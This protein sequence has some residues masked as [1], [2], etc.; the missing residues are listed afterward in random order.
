M[1]KLLLS[2]FLLSMFL[3]SQ[4]INKLILKPYVEGK[5]MKGWVIDSIRMN[6]TATIVY[7]QFGLGRG[8]TSSGDLDS[9]I[10]IPVTGKHFKQTGLK[11]LPF[12]PEKII[13]I[14]Q[15][16]HFEYIFPP[17]DPATKCINITNN[18]FDGRGA[19]WYGVWLVPRITVFTEQLSKLSTIEG[20]WYAYNDTG[21]WKAGFYEH[22]IFWN[23]QFWNF[24][25]L[26][27]TDNSATIELF[28]NKGLKN[29]LVLTMSLDSILKVNSK[30][31]QLLLTKKPTIKL[32]DKSEFNN[33]L[34]ANDSLTV[35]GYYQVANPL[36][37]K[38]NA[39]IVSD[40]L[41]DKPIIYPVKVLDDGTFQ[42]KIPYSFTSKVT[43]SNQLGPRS[44]LSEVTFYAEPG[45]HIILT[46]R[47]ENEKAVVFGG[48][49]QRV[50]NEFTTFSNANPY[51][52]TDRMLSD[53]VRAKIDEFIPWRKDLNEKLEKSY[54][55]WVNINTTSTKFQDVIQNKLKYA[56]IADVLKASTYSRENRNFD[57]FIVPSSDSAF[58]NNPKAMYCEEYQ[59][60]LKGMTN[61]QKRAASFDGFDICNIIMK[62]GFPTESEKNILERFL[63][64]PR[65]F[66]TKEDYD[67]Y[68]NFITENK[69]QLDSI[70][71]KN[72]LLIVEL[73]NNKAEEAKMK[74]SLP[75][76]I[77]TDFSTARVFGDFLAKETES[78]SEEQVTILKSDCKN[79]ELV[80]L[81]LQ[82]NNELKAK[83]EIL[84]NAKLPIGVNTYFLDETTKDLTKAIT[85]KYKGKVIYVDF[86]ATWCG[87]CKA[88][89]PYSEKRKEDFNGKDVVF[90]YITGDSSP[91]LVWKKMITDISG[92]HFKLTKAQWKSICDQY[93]VTGI[94]HY[95]I[96]DKKGKIVNDKAPRPSN[97]TELKNAIEKLL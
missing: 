4:A 13:G 43:F 60:V 42:I 18:D 17:I 22:K 12:A 77:A 97:E 80:N 29:S 44:P 23:N 93:N 69:N 95:L 55:E 35:T 16:I 47:N 32:V 26:K 6:D 73:K 88:E 82:K 59:N 86:W 46:Y 24:K 65:I 41:S 31:K 50:N 85:E 25:V 2:C 68:K 20:N 3:S 94:P 48:D 61:F 56:L 45:N 15:H 40:L 83:I 87:P 34:S 38:K 89:M 30:G 62:N 57:E 5:G 75:K 74:Y 27:C 84:K 14:G 51:F 19:A 33:K 67:T 66:E 52:P 92:E 37:T 1:K 79:E 39:L 96:F 81:I 36:F 78:L 58:Y 10:E 76:G 70:F 21:D 28:N 8:S 9:Y 53:K 72:Q 90:V 54:T 11:G 64:I 7:G 49:N 71:K 91:D 63:Q